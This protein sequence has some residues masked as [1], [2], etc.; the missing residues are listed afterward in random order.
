MQVITHPDP[1]AMTPQDIADLGV[2]PPP[3]DMHDDEDNDEVAL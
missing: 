1:N 2:M 3:S